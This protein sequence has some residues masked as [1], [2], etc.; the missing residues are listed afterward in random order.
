MQVILFQ[1]EI[2]QNTG[3]IIRTCAVTGCGLILVEPCGFATT[4]RMMKRAGL[5]YFNEI[6]ISKIDNLEEFL[7]NTDKPFYFL[8]SKTSKSISD[9]K[10]EKDCLLIFGNETSG[11]PDIFIKKYPDR[12]FTIPMKKNMRCYNLANSV[13]VAIYE[14]KRQNGFIFS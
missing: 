4:N 10:F 6:K 1:P 13:A 12:F 9:A 5:D 2:P 7:N 3:N 8:S 11:L 14:A